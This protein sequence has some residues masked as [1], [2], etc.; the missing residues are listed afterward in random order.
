M[1]THKKVRVQFKGRT[2]G[3]MDLELHGNAVHEVRVD[4]GEDPDRPDCNEFVRDCLEGIIVY[5]GDT[6]RVVAADEAAATS[7]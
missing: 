2:G 1:A 6:V 7:F 4:P 5:P 3:W